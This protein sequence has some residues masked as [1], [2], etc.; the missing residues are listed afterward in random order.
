MW[1]N[2]W[3]KIC[4]VSDLLFVETSLA[5]SLH[6]TSLINWFKWILTVLI[7]LLRINTMDFLIV[8]GYLIKPSKRRAKDQNTATPENKN[9]RCQKRA[10]LSSG[11]SSDELS[12]MS[13]WTHKS[14]KTSSN[15]WDEYKLHMLHNPAPQIMFRNEIFLM[16]QFS[17]DFTYVID[18]V[19][20]AEAV[21]YHF[22]LESWIIIIYTQRA[23]AK[24]DIGWCGRQSW[25]KLTE[26][27]KMPS[28]KLF[29]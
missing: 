15:V 14:C 13:A 2:E 11:P 20:S 9:I 6:R 7:T 19:P 17:H 25:G 23:R 4:L 26:I 27:R 8:F 3:E 22:W 10:P 29:K 5:T 24:V 16:F 12:E 21:S 1:R 28:P 18:L